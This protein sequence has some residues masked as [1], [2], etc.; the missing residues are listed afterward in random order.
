MDRRLGSPAARDQGGL[1]AVKRLLRGAQ[2]EWAEREGSLGQAHV[3]QGAA[4][5]WRV[6]K[7]RVCQQGQLWNSRGPLHDEKSGP[8][9]IKLSTI[10]RR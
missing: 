9:L 4:S 8:S 2:Q 3:R 1:L 6:R 10:S 7:P 5:A